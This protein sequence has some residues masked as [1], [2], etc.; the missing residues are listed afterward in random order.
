MTK[1]PTHYRRH[2]VLICALLFLAAVQCGRASFQVNV[3]YIDLQ[4]YAAGT[5]RMP[6]QGRIGM[7]PIVRWAEDNPLLIRSAAV[8]NDALQRTPQHAS[9]PETLGPEKL[10]C[11]LLGCVAVVV[12]T[13][14]ATAYTTRHLPELWWMGGVVTLAILYTSYAA[15]AELNFWYPYDLPHFALF[16]LATLCILEGWWPAFFALFLIDT[17][18]RETSVYLLL[19]ASVVAWQR[20]QR[21][22]VAWTAAAFFLFWLPVRL[23]IGHHFAANLSETGIRPIGIL[24][25]VFN[26]LHWPQLLSAGGYLFLPMWLARKYLARD[27]QWF[28]YAALPCLAVTLAFG[29]WYETRI[30]GE[31][32]LSLAVLAS[33][34]IAVALK[35]VFASKQAPTAVA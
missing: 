26:P 27:Q 6:Y 1:Q 9:Q 34:E 3:S 15:R 14:A 21:Y 2:K 10:I 22:L 8:I 24:H 31:W 17:P 13:F 33:T 32:T 7:E 4:R 12:M 23:W 18:V 19:L 11:L 16:G 25:A 20:G 35:N 28:L 29:M 30:F 5:E